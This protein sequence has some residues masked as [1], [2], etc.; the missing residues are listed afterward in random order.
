MMSIPQITVNLA[1]PDSIPTHPTYYYWKIVKS[2]EHGVLKYSV[3]SVEELT[4]SETIQ[5]I[6]MS[7]ICLNKE[8]CQKWK[9]SVREMGKSDED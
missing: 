5:I 3:H 6:I 1:G 4:R 7:K 2:L 8:K 9:F